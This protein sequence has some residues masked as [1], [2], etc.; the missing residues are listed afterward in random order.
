MPI[1]F[2][3]NPSDR[4]V[5]MRA[6]GVLDDHSVNLVRAEI[7]KHPDLDPSMVQLFDMRS[8][9]QITLSADSVRALAAGSIFGSRSRRAF[10]TGNDF[11]FGMARMFSLYSETHAQ[12]VEVFREVD[13]ALLWLGGGPLPEGK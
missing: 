5:V 12:T 6:A 10:V 7:R 2:D 11:Q 1:T 4:I 8:A 3:I 9:E 13:S